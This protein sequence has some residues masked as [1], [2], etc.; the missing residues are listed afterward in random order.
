MK[1][2]ELFRK[3]KIAGAVS[4]LSISVITMNLQGTHG[5]TGGGL[6][7][8]GELGEDECECEYEEGEV[9]EYCEDRESEGTLVA[10]ST[11]STSD[12]ELPEDISDEPIPEDELDDGDESGLLDDTDD[13]EDENDLDDMTDSGDENEPDDTI[14]PGDGNEPGDGDTE[15]GDGG[16]EPGDDGTEPSDG[17]TE[18]GD[19]DTE[20]GDGDTEPGD[21]D[22]EPG[23]GDTEPGD[24]DTEPGDGG[25]EPGDGNETGTGDIQ[26]PNIPS[27]PDLNVP[28]PPT[29]S[30][31]PVIP[32]PPTSSE[33]PDPP[34]TPV[35]TQ[36]PA[37]PIV[38]QPLPETAEPP[39]PPQIA[40]PQN[41]SAV[42]FIPS[43]DFLHMRDREVYNVESGI[44]GLPVFIT[45]EMIVG[46]LKTQDSH[47]FPASV[48]I[49]QVIQEG[50]YGRF[51]PHG[52]EGQGLSYLSYRYNNLFGIKGT[53]SAGSVM[54]RTG[55]MTPAG[56]R[57]MITDRFR[58]YNTVTEAFM[59]RAQLL[60]EVYWDLIEG[61]TDANTFAVRIGGRWATDIH[62]ARHLIRHMENYDLYRLD[63][64]TLEDYGAIMGLFVH[65]VP[66]SV[67]TSP[68]GWRDW[69]NAFHRGVDF[70]TGA[71]HLP[72]YAVQSGVVTFAGWANCAGW[73]IEITHGNGLVTRYMHHEQNFVRVGQEVV[74]GQQIAVTGSTGRSTGNHLHFE[75]H[76][77][78][79]AVNPMLF[80]GNPIRRTENRADGTHTERR[81]IAGETNEREGRGVPIGL[82]RTADEQEVRNAPT[83]REIVRREVTG[84]AR[85]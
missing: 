15:P 12:A 38:P 28:Q 20:P 84:N 13:L 49:A 9:C 63:D 60:T 4:A 51:G 24:G 43:R 8:A 41:T 42:N 75:V 33:V 62:Y 74:Q 85:N 59:D 73:W 70:G 57:F 7:L 64:M 55:E 40:P 50:G 54:M 82:R 18:P 46:A 36:P 34:Q 1:R 58:V 23:D 32:Q 80:L 71:S 25:T 69:D 5:F 52:D 44:E 65:P 77:N 10:D 31:T 35:S 3:L 14:N 48:A 83:R 66:G 17:G 27:R 76:V 53:S 19:G 26:N 72:V 11:T 6:R 30:E 61:V 16:T 22:T 39:P 47:G 29:R 37:V 68:F 21:G 78:G 45:Q 2:K 81:R 56:V 79:I 67:L